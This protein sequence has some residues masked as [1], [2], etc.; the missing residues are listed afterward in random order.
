MKTKTAIPTGTLHR[1]GDPQ[2]AHAGEWTPSRG[3]QLP[4]SPRSV[5]STQRAFCW[6]ALLRSQDQETKRNFS[7][8]LHFWTAFHASKFCRS[9]YINFFCIVFS[10]ALLPPTQMGTK[11]CSSARSI[12]SS[13][14]EPSPTP[15]LEDQ[16]HVLDFPPGTEQQ[17]LQN[18]S[19][20]SGEGQQP[21]G[22]S[23]KT[24][25]AESESS[26]PAGPRAAAEGIFVPCNTGELY[27]G[28]SSELRPLTPRQA[29]KPFQVPDQK[30]SAG[31]GC[32]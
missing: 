16:K 21:L 20:G 9:S 26:H 31:T 14:G 3:S 13:T 8:H 24:S 2:G 10:K 1:F 19:E 4:P 22:C 6:G 17:G 23:S 30:S 5:P 12:A 7:I 29:S 27:P 32:P 18:L 15:T 25:D 11:S 28:P